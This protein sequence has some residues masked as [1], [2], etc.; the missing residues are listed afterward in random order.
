MSQS[1]SAPH[2][3]K[4][5]SLKYPRDQA[6]KRQEH[7]FEMVIKNNNS[8]AKMVCDVNHVVLGPFLCSLEPWELI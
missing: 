4:H 1:H 5:E 7:V 3:I 6:L 8:G 2:L